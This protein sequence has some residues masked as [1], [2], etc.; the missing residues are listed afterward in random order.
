M[1]IYV[2][3]K[4]PVNIAKRVK[5]IPFELDNAPQTLRE[6]VRESVFTC[7]RLYRERAAASDFP[8]PLS[9]ADFDRMKEIGKFAFGVHYNENDLNEE[10]AVK[11]AV[12]AINDGLVRIFRNN[13]ELCVLDE[14]INIAE[15]DVFTF[16]RLTF[17]SGRLW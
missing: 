6:L 15:G 16:V 8:M 1:R 9:D 13:E 5:E 12:E 11:T 10:E 4:S 3:V 17:L 14:K 2:C 7:I